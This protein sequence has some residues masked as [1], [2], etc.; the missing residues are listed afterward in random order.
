MEAAKMK[1]WIVVLAAL[2]LAACRMDDRGNV[3]P[4]AKTQTA[5]AEAKQQTRDAAADLQAGAAD[6]GNEAQRR[7][8]EIGQTEAA[9]RVANGAR[10]A[11]RGLKQGAGEAAEAAG[12]AL[13]RE[14]QEAQAESKQQPAPKTNT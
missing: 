1:Q 13:K 8:Q 5:A 11:A 14:G 6:I 10:E 3:T 7:A 9:Q 2:A 4:T 12:D